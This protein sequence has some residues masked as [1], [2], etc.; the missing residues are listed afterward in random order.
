MLPRDLSPASFRGVRF[1]V[2]SD[3]AEEGRNSIRHAYPDASFHYL[4]DNGRHPPEFKISALLHGDNLPAKFASLRSA[5]TRPGPGLLKHPYY[6][7]QLC[8][9]DGKFRVKRDDR[10]AGVIEIEIPFSVT[11]PPAL[12]GAVSG[13]AAFVTGLATS[14]LT[15]LFQSFAGRYGAP[16]SSTSA[17]AVG[18]AIS[19]IGAVVDA[20]FSSAGTAGAALQRHSTRLGADGTKLADAL[21]L[22]ISQP[23]FDDD[24]YTS[25][26]IIAGYM[27]VAAAAASACDMADALR[28]DTLD[29]ARRQECLSLIGS[30]MQTGA[31]L[32]VAEG[33]ASRTYTNADDVARDEARLT[34]LLD[35]VQGR[36]LDGDVHS[37]MLDVY[38]AASEVLAAIAVRQPRLTT[39]RTGPLPASVLAYQLRGD[40]ALAATLVELNLEQP[41]VLFVGDVVALME[42]SV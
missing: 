12:P 1:L 11:G 15:S 21:A 7:R 39:I 27:E 30:H 16:I 6:G 18:S 20:K 5:L 3:T 41:P 42:R 8:M 38:T 25:E 26:A 10:D 13:V 14:A 36:D 2:P 22:A 29:K 9:V 37:A 24:T 17:L 34:D 33:M 35:A 19:A 32:A 40:D 23:T 28:A 4:E 31:F